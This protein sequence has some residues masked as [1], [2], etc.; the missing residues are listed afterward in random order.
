R[1]EEAVDRRHTARQPVDQTITKEESRR[2]FDKDTDWA[3]EVPPSSPPSSEIF[4][5]LAWTSAEI[6]A[7][8]M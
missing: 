7:Q 5:L 6:A 3:E 8:S 2:L 4:L 1:V